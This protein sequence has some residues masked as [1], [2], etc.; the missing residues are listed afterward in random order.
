MGSNERKTFQ[1]LAVVDL[2]ENQVDLVR[3]PEQKKILHT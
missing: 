3:Q 2:Y 1:H